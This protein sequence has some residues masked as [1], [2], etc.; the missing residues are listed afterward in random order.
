[1]RRWKV[2]ARSPA[3]GRHSRRRWRGIIC[4]SIVSIARSNEIAVDTVSVVN[5]NREEVAT[6]DVTKEQRTTAD[7]TYSTLQ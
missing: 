1:M 2:L 4:N 3:A 5:A 7:K 6:C